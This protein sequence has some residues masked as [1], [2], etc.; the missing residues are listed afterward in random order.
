VAE[1]QGN[2]YSGFGIASIGGYHAAKPRLVQDLF[3]AQLERNLAWM[4][5]LNVRYLVFPQ[6][7]DPPPTY[8]RE[9][10]SGSQVVYENLLALPRVTVLGQY[11]VVA[12]ARAILDSVQ[13]TT[14]ESVDFAFFDRDPKLQLGPVDG[15]RAAIVSYRLNEVEVDVQ[16]PGPSL[17]RLADLWHPD[18]TATVD[19]RPTPV[20]RSDY[21]LRAVAVPA[22]SHRVTFRFR[23]AAVR[24]GL[25]LSLASLVLILAL[26]GADRLLVRRRAGAAREAAAPGVA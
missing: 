23:S 15:A 26:F 3:D 11:A 8:L 9:V 20:L 12:P 25:A 17:L 6:P 4:R 2:R 22:G 5:L 7:L 18:W 19:G 14:R 24:H 1:F 10:H 16:S 13:Q 21:L